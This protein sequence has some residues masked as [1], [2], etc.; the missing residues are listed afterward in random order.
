M[1]V[2]YGYKHLLSIYPLNPSH[3]FSHKLSLSLFRSEMFLSQL[4]YFHIFTPL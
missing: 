1:K 4:K 3:A 2:A